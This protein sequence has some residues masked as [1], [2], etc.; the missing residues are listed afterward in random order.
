LYLVACSV[1]PSFCHLSSIIS[2]PV[3]I[4]LT[5]SGEG[6]GGYGAKAC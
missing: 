2:S 5:S 6:E 4:C 1:Q 3:V